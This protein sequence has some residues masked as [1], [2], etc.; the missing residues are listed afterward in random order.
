MS[1]L[2]WLWEAGI[3]HWRIIQLA[4]LGFVG[5]S[6][7]G[8]FPDNEWTGTDGYSY[9]NPIGP[10]VFFRWLNLNDWHSLNDKVR[11]GNPVIFNLDKGQDHDSIDLI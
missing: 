7:L 8:N 10:L 5:P 3:T 1:D 11:I 4:V 9:V 2:Y 6:V